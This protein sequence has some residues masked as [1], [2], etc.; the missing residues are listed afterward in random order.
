MCWAGAVGA[1]CAFSAAC[2]GSVDVDVGEVE[3]KCG[4]A[5]ASSA[6]CGVAKF[7]LAVVCSSLPVFSKSSQV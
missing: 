4:R 3:E 5:M 2:C 1:D 7:G 6:H